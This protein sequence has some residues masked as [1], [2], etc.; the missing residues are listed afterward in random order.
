MFSERE[1]RRPR[2]WKAPSRTN[3][4]GRSRNSATKTKNG[5]IGRYVGGSP[6]A[7]RAGPARGEAGSVALSRCDVGRHRR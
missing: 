7:S 2:V 4:V 6:R 5:S 3:T 1:R